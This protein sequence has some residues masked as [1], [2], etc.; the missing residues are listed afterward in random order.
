[1]WA[2]F[3]EELI[4][5][6]KKENETTKQIKKI[7]FLTSFKHCNVVNSLINTFLPNTVANHEANMLATCIVVQLGKQWI[8]GSVTS[9]ISAPMQTF[10][11]QLQHEPTFEGRIE[12]RKKSTKTKNPWWQD[13][14]KEKKRIN[15]K[16]SVELR[17]L[18]FQPRN[19]MYVE[20]LKTQLTG[21]LSFH[22]YHCHGELSRKKCKLLLQEFQ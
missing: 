7:L 18:E 10:Y 5:T 4:C 17:S 12:R 11:W 2:N 20:P 8:Y 16:G 19:W 14:E 22:F 1:M 21:W 3:C 13:L 6:K 15:Q 9:N